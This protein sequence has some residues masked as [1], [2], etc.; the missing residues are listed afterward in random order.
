[1][2]DICQTSLFSTFQVPRHDCS[3][4]AVNTSVED[5]SQPEAGSIGLACLVD[6]TKPSCDLPDVTAI[7]SNQVQREAQS[8]SRM[9]GMPSR[10]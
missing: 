10:E 3:R 4:Q 7:G 2:P 6:P 5:S 8:K 1:M 9:M